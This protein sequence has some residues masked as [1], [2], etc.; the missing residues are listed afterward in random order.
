MRL[1]D[2]VPLEPSRPLQGVYPHPACP[3]HQ[4]PAA[5][6]GQEEGQHF[7]IKNDDDDSKEK[8]YFVHNVNLP[9]YLTWHENF[10]LV[11]YFFRNFNVKFV[12]K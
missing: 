6:R 12:N 3:E 1:R 4:V 9:T 5:A 11:L 7:Q 2:Q 8:N 10:C